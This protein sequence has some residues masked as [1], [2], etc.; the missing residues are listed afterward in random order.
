MIAKARA[1]AKDLMIH[2]EKKGYVIPKDEH[3]KEALEVVITE[4]RRKDISPKD[5]ISAA[6]LL[7]TYT[8]AKP[9]TETTMNVRKAED[10]LNDLAL[11][12]KD[13]K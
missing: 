11:E 2:M 4:M 10:F 7:L 13:D 5:K 3:A 1:E 6:A 8:L 9:A 12:M